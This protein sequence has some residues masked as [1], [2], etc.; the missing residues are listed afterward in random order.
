MV[1]E[2]QGTQ[3]FQ[4]T[5]L[6]SKYCAEMT[7]EGQNI[8]KFT[9]H[10]KQ[11]RVP[12]IIYADFEALNILIKGCADNPEKSYTRQIAKQVSCS[13]CYVVFRS[14]A[15]AK[16]LVLFRCEDAVEH[17]LSSLQAELVEINEVF[18]KPVDMIITA[19]DC[20]AFNDSPDCHIWGEALNDDRVRDNC[21]I[22]GNIAVQLTMHAT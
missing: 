22:T 3:S 8:L 20:K 13:Y 17:F 16:A 2:T 7:K 18:K 11:M 12:Y 5:T 15:E 14:E 6:A 9:N 19:N 21:L 4:S 1:V 10:H